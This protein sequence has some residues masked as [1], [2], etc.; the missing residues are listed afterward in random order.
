MYYWIILTLCTYKPVQSGSQVK[1]KQKNILMQNQK[2]FFHIF[3]VKYD[4][5]LSNIC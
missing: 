2:F 1:I 3:E 5:P 4:G